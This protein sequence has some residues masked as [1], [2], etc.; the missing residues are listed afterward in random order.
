M[1]YDAGIREYTKTDVPMMKRLWIEVFGDEPQLVDRF[2]E[3][4]PS[5]GTALCAFSGDEFLGSVYLLQSEIW[6]NGRFSKKLAYMYALAVEPGA[7][8][9]G[10]GGKLVRVARRFCWENDLGVLCM[11]PAEASL[12]GWYARIAGFFPASFCEYEEI[13]AGEEIDGITELCADEYG[14]RRGELLKDQN[15]VNY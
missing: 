6:E 15:Y 9:F 1:Y 7:R 8:G 12:Y 4:L 11:L 2:F 14:F 3:L 5:M 13:A 10:V